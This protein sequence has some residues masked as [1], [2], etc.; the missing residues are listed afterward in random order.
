MKF[1]KLAI[2]TMAFA[3]LGG[4]ASC[5]S[6]LKDFNLQIS[7]EVIRHSAVLQVA[8]ADGSDISNATIRLIGGDMDDIYN[9]EGR[10]TFQLANG[11]VAFGVNP[12]REVMPGAPVTFQVEI[13]AAGYT[14]QIVTV[15]ISNIN[16]GIQAVRLVRPMNLP[17]G[18]ASNTQT[19][20]LGANGATTT[21]VT[22]GASDNASGVEVSIA[23]PAGTQF[24]DANGN[25]IQGGT[26]TVNTLGFDAL[27]EDALALFPGGSLQAEGVIGPD[28]ST[29]SGTFNPAAA[30]TIDMNVGGVAVRQFSQP[31]QITMDVSPD[32]QLS[33]GAA[34][35][36]NTQLV[37][38]S[39]SP[40]D[41][42]W[43]YQQTAMVTGSAASGYSLSFATDHLTTFVGGE[44]IKSCA[45]V[46]EV[47]FTGE[48]ITQGFT[49]PVTVEALHHGQVISTRTFSVSQGNQTIALENLPASDVTVVV[50]NTVGA[51]VA[52]G[53]LAACGTTTQ[54][55]IP[56]PPG[57]FVTL[58][59]YVR[60][61]NNTTPITLL[62]TF[63]MEYRVTGTSRWSYLGEVNNGFLS[64]TLLKADGTRYDFRATWKNR[65]KVVAGKTVVE[66]NI[67]TVGVQPGDI[68]GEK[69]GATNLAILTEECN[70]L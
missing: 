66:S 34:L 17:D 60:C 25:V 43:T 31:I 67:A 9:L 58:Q 24:L 38:Y 30:T 41:P 19:V 53:P 63:Q 1:K 33:T 32:F 2:Y 46:S 64:T 59:L 48:W 8:G 55:A 22:V 4:V 54:I 29:S 51:V 26:L 47:T 56:N 16:N 20:A 6:P 3:L 68:I 49:Y 18:V 14:T 45:A 50:R 15:A 13:A 39:F 35:T 23:I 69:A 61:P 27:S 37:S 44:F 57:T 5:E 28:G 36:P 21:A 12:N 7:T 10:K 40:S 52:Q 11:F 62:P 42:V 70:G 65:T